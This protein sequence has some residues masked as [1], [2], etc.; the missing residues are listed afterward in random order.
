MAQKG[1]GPVTRPTVR[2][3][4]TERTFRSRSSFSR[5]IWFDHPVDGSRTKGELVD[6]ILTLHIPKAEDKESVRVN[7]A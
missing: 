4:S 1:E 6:G 7:I 3:I 5:T 2:H